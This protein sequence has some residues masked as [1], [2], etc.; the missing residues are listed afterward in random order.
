MRQLIVCTLA[1][2]GAAA[3]AAEL[4]V[5]RLTL[6]DNLFFPSVLAVPSGVKFKLLIANKDA[7]P[8]EFD[9]FD[10]NR[11]KVIFGESE[12]VIYVGPLPEG[13]YEYFGEYHPATAR[14]LIKASGILPS[15]AQVGNNKQEQPRAD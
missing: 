14:G 11:E 1:L 10:L 7:S 6:Q 5:Y 9:S 8:E 3:Q 15:D 13:R 2:L 12:A 4:P